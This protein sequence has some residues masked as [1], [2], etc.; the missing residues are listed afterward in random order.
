VRFIFFILDNLISPLAPRVAPRKIII[1][2][3]CVINEDTTRPRTNNR[4][5]IEFF[6]KDTG[7]LFCGVPRQGKKYRK[8][9]NR[10]YLCKVVLSITQPSAVYVTVLLSNTIS[11][12]LYVIVL[13]AT[14]PPAVY[15]AFLLVIPYPCGLFFFILDNL[16]PPLAPP[17]WHPAK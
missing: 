10:V 16:I 11:L 1:G 7:R 5:S 9:Q 3:C 2:S 14:Q 8:R 12:R 6:V 15:V 4:I 13:L 17:A